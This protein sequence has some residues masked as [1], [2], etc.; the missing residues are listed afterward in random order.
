MDDAL[1]P[2]V[3]ALEEQRCA[4]TTQRD[5]AALERLL[6]EDLIYTHSSGRVETKAAFLESIRAGNPRYHRIERS[7]VVVRIY[8]DVVAVVTGVARFTV[9]LNGQDKVSFARF[10]NVWTRADAGQWRFS[11]WQATPCAMGAER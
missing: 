1:V 6:A 10:T 7:D 3:L 2:F 8:H 5:V 4:A 9:T 11:A